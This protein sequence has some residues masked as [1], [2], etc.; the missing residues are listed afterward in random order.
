MKQI[1]PFIVFLLLAMDVLAQCSMCGAVA[2]SN[3]DAGGDTG[4]GLNT[5]ILYLM[6]LPYILV[7]GI[8]VIFFRK[9]IKEKIKRLRSS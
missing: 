4:K 1:V 3:I 8:T 7:G 5:G 6:A 9:Q 2:S